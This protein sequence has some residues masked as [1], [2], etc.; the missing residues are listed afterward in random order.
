ML[1]E[2]MKTSS[3]STAANSPLSLSDGKVDEQCSAFSPFDSERDGVQF[4]LD[5][6][7]LWQLF[8]EHTNEMIVT[9]AGR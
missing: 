2:E 6:A 3:P 9:R 1:K 8:A 4:R 7:E 5:E